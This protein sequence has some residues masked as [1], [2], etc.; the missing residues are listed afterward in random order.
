MWLVTLTHP[1]NTSFSAQPT[2]LS[3]LILKELV[4]IT[5]SDTNARVSTKNN[6]TCFVLHFKIQKVTISVI[7]RTRYISERIAAM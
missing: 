1:S 2:D 7:F 4:K 3:V 5:K 6:L